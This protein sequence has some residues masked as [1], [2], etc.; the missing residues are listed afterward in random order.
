MVERMAGADGVELCTESFGDPADPAVLLVMGAG[1]SMLWWEEGFCRMLAGGGRLVIRYDHRDTGRSTSYPPGRPGYTGAD[2]VDDAARVLDGYGIPAAHV[3]GVSAG[4]ALAQLLALG[5][6][7]RVLSLVLISTSSAVPD[8][9]ELPAPTEEFMRFA[10]A[11]GPDPSDTEAVVAHQVAYARLLAGGRRPFDESA[12]RDLV[13]REVERARDVAAARN[14]DTLAEGE[15]PRTPL[16]SIA[17][18]VLVVHGTADPMFPLAHGEA[19]A[20]RIPGARLLTLADAGH[21]VDRADWPAVVR[22]VLDHTAAGER[23]GG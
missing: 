21:G 2:L 6:P 8:D 12:A 3:A 1:A 13:R 15:H 11:D 9:R 18:P 7:D 10:S 4:G 20:E 19:L 5:A 17:V 14:H 22:A 16:S 23:P